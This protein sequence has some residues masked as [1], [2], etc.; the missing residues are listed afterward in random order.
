MYTREEILK[1]RELARLHNLK[2]CREFWFSPIE[3]MQKHCNGV[4][5]EAMLDIAVEALN[6]LYKDY[7]VC[8]MGHDLDYLLKRISK[9]EADLTFYKNMIII[10]KAKF[11]WRRFFPR[12]LKDFFRIRA[13]YIA[14]KKFGQSAWD[15]CGGNT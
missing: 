2:M 9:K 6:F 12:G 15:N 3:Y 14:V 7:Q 11:G 8:A 5:S 1:A 10:W 4:G 13:A